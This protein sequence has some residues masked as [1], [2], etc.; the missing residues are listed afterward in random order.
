[1]FTCDVSIDRLEQVLLQGESLI[2]QVRA[3]QAEALAQ[4]EAAQVIQHDGSRNMVDWTAAQLP[5]TPVREG[6]PPTRRPVQRPR[7]PQDAPTRAARQH[8]GF[9]G[10]DSLS[11]LDTTSVVSADPL[12]TV[13]L[14]GD[15]AANT[16]GETGAEV[17]FGPRVGPATL[18]RI[19]CSGAVQVIL[20]QTDGLVASHATRAI[21]PVIRRYVTWRD[22]GCSI[23]GCTSRYRLEP[24]HVRHRADG[25]GHDPDNLTTLC[26]YHHHVAVHGSGYRIDPSSPPQ[27]RRLRPTSGAD[28]PSAEA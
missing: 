25:G 4:L 14:D 12:V 17:E 20:N 1:M 3:R 24:H 16:S 28:P 18:E 6:A 22:G 27:R 7:R 2:S 19:L 26:W 9:L 13:F 10:Q 11:E 8:P 15:L 23:D 5:S 21:P